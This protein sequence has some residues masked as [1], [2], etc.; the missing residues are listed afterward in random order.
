MCRSL[1]TVVDSFFSLPKIAIFAHI[2]GADSNSFPYPT[3]EKSP[4]HVKE[5]D[6]CFFLC[7]RVS[8]VYLLNIIPCRTSVAIVV[9]CPLSVTSGSFSLLLFWFLFKVSSPPGFSFLHCEFLHPFLPPGS[10]FQSWDLIVK[11]RGKKPAPQGPHLIWGC[12]IHY[13]SPYSLSDFLL[14]GQNSCNS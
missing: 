2:D 8:V 3:I 7:F 10:A 5:N 13:L 4:R 6:A 1:N 12:S 14:V 11:C 9:V